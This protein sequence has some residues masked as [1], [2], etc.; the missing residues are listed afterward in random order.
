MAVSSALKT[1]KSETTRKKTSL[2]MKSELLP[3]VVIKRLDFDD[4]RPHL[5]EAC[6]IA[7][8]GATYPQLR[9]AK[10]QAWQ[11]LLWNKKYRIPKIQRTREVCNIYGEKIATLPQQ[12]RR[13]RVL[14]PCAWNPKTWSENAKNAFKCRE[15][16]GKG[17]CKMSMS[18]SSLDK[19]TYLQK[20]GR[21]KRNFGRQY[22]WTVPNNRAT[23]KYWRHRK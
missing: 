21:E 2:L 8:P 23:N 22:Q 17:A 18:T 10:L 20:K 15:K 19:C 13:N 7:L 1:F 5:F 16:I 3:D 9:D 12:L 4:I 11:H 6:L 14:L